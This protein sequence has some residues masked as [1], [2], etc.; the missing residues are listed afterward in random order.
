MSLKFRTAYE[1][2]NDP[3][4]SDKTVPKQMPKSQGVKQNMADD[5]DINNIMKRYEST[6]AL[7][8][9]IRAQP[10]YGDFSDPIDYQE[11]LNIVRFAQEQFEAL[12]ARV[13]ER[14][15]NDPQKFLEFTGDPENREE[16]VKLGLATKREE[17]PPTG[18]PAK[19]ASAASG[20]PKPVDPK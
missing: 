7:P 18:T 1:P 13:R 3:G 10:R 14:F 11:S 20:D 9:M 15:G 5:T 6:G 4:Y 8:Q 12:P 17:A 19:T 2:S 16:M